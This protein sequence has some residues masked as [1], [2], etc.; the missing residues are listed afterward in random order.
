MLLSGG[1]TT[2]TSEDLNSRVVVDSPD[3]MTQA[4]S[5]G[6]IFLVEHNLTIYNTMPSD[7]GI[8]ECRAASEE[9]L[10]MPAQNF[11]LFVQG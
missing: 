1:N 8:Y 10:A 5:G 2:F 6:D 9:G 4:T 3:E 11:T 7:S